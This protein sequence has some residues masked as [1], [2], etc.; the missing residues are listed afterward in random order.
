MVPLFTGATPSLIHSPSLK[1]LNNSSKFEN[2]KE[3]TDENTTAHCYVPMLKSPGDE[4]MR[5][6]HPLNGAVIIIIVLRPPPFVVLGLL[7]LRLRSL[8]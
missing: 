8:P 4:A 5:R 2:I 6:A 3:T 1:R 7:S